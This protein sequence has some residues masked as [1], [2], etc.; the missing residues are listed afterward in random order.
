MAISAQHLKE[1]IYPDS[2]GKPM[3]ENTDQYDYLTT[4]KAGLAAQF[5]DSADVF[6]AGDLLWYP[7]QGRPDITVA[8]DV[9]IAFGRP[10]G[11]RGSYKQWEEGNVAPQVIFEILSPGNTKREMQGK[12]NFYHRY[13]VE[14][15]YE[16]DPENGTLE[17]WRRGGEFFSYVPIEGECTSPRLNIKLK[18]EDSGTLSVFHPNGRKFELTEDA[19]IRANA[20]EARAERLAAKLRELGI[21]PE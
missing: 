19:I 5:K 7:V 12:R 17:C 2:D 9:L 6:V 3:A 16:Y 10:P 11:R 4:I 18:L 14:E 20:A 15:Y 1:I 13:G 8:P 21:E